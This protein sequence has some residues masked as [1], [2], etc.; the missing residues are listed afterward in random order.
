MARYLEYNWTQADFTDVCKKQNSVDGKLTLN[1]NFADG[2]NQS[3][4]FIKQGFIR[5]ASIASTDD[6]SKATITIQG[7]QFGRPLK[8]SGNGPGANQIVE[9]E[10]VFFD[11]ITGISSDRAITNVAAGTGL[12]GYIK[13]FGINEDTISLLSSVAVFPKNIKYNIYN[14]PLHPN[15]RQIQDLKDYFLKID[16]TA[17]DTFLEVPFFSNLSLSTAFI[18]VYF[19]PTGNDP[20]T[21]KVVFSQTLSR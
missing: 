20:A 1:G 19:E 11:E 10:G 21:A 2:A 17:A 8:W 5:T 13:P 16:G 6:L 12:K 14:C 18:I 15:G 4:S 9:S 7:T 3:I